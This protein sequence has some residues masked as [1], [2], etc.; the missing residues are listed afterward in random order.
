MNPPFHD[1]R[2]ADPG[3]G[4]AMIRAASAA[5]KPSGQLFM[6]ANRGLPYEL[7]MKAG[8]GRVEEIADEQ[9]FRVWRARR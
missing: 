9:G 6:V 7:P 1:G 3:I 4:H 8:F 5:L 2:A